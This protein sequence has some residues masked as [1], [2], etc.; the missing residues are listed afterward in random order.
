MPTVVTK[1]ESFLKNQTKEQFVQKIIS[2]IDKKCLNAYV[3]GS[4]YSDKFHA[5][6][7]FDLIIILETDKSFLLR[8]LLFSEL[9]DYKNEHNIPLDLLVYTPAEFEKLVIEGKTSKAGFWHDVV[10]TYKK[11]L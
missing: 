4:F 9:L 10:N 1:K 11:I 2:L 3:F 6:S 7:D 8:A 5:E